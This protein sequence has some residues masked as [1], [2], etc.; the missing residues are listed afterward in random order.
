MPRRRSASICR[1]G[2]LALQESPLEH[3][4]MQRPAFGDVASHVWGVFE[5]F[6]GPTDGSSANGGTPSNRN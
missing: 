2:L 1:E 4:V 6:S 3:A 5:V